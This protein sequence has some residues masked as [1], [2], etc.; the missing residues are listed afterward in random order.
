VHLWYDLNV[1]YTDNKK[2]KVTLQKQGVQA[3]FEDGKDDLIFIA[4]VLKPD[5]DWE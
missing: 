4:V 1:N 2:V 3:N 5:P